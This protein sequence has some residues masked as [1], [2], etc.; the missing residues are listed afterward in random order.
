LEEGM[1]TENK[2]TLMQVRRKASLTT[3]EVADLAGVPLRV[4]YL[5][6]IGGMTEREDVQ[7]ILAALGTLTQRTYTVEDLSEVNI[8]LVKPAPAPKLMWQE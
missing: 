7:K 6:E 5:M 1:T 8:R 2:P 4:A 3:R